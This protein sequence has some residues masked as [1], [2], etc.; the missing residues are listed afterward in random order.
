MVLETL[1]RRRSSRD[2][3]GYSS[4]EEGEIVILADVILKEAKVGELADLWGRMVL[5]EKGRKEVEK[6]GEI[7]DG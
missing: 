3:I 1:R 5:V 6:S 2:N 4:Q 7:V